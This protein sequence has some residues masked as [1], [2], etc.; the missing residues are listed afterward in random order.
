MIGGGATVGRATERAG[1]EERILAHGAGRF[2]GDIHGNHLERRATTVHH[3][4]AGAAAD[5]LDDRGE[6]GAEFLG[7][8]RGVHSWVNLS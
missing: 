6:R 8:D 1:A 2:G 3:R 5:A 4:V 7:G